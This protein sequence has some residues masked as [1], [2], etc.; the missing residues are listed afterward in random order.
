MLL[1]EQVLPESIYGKI[2]PIGDGIEPDFGCYILLPPN[3]S[4]DN[5]NQQL[6]AYSQKMQSADNKDSHIIQPLSAV[7]YDTANR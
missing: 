4:V 1:T 3:I 2:T 5:F 7:H 6:R